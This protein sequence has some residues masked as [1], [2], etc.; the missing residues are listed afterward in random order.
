MTTPES[1]DLGDSGSALWTALTELVD[2]DV[3]ETS[4]LTEACRIKDRLDALDVIIRA[5]GVT[6][7]SPQGVKAHPAVVE[8][9][10]QQLTLARLLASLR[11]PDEDDVRPQR[12]GAARGSYSRKV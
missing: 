8:A 7:T 5:E 4:L 3:H 12:R 10:N 2:F 1:L 11:I 6:V 9:R